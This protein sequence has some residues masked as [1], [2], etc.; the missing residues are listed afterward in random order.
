M[1]IIG[2]T[3]S[4]ACGKSTVSSYLISRGFPVVD[5]DR[6]SRNLTSEGSPV[7]Q[8][9]YREFGPDVFCTDGSLNRRRLGRLVFNDQTARKKLDD[10]MAP[11]LY[12]STRCQI[13]ELAS[14]GE[15]LCF[16]DMP[17]LFEKGYDKLCD[18][19]WTVWLPE[20]IQIT[21]LM[22]R[23]GFSREESLKRIRSVL[24]SDEKAALADKIIDNSGSV[25]QTYAAVADLIAEESRARKMQSD[26]SDNDR[27]SVVRH[28]S[29]SDFSCSMAHTEPAVMKRPDTARRNRQVR[30]TAWRLPAWLKVSLITIAA[31][32]LVGITAQILMRAYLHNQQELHASEQL[33][34]DRQYPL[35]YRDLIIRY[36]S[37]YN[38]SPA[39]VSAI[40]RNE[41]SFQAR[42]ESGAGAR[43]LM[44][45]MPETA[46]WIAGKLQVAGYAFERMYDPE[47]NI[48]FGCW[49]LNY[50]SRL[51][52][53]DPVSVAAAYHAGQGQVKTWL[54]DPLLSED[55]YTM[56]VESLPEGPTKNYTRRVLRDYGIYQEKYFTKDDFPPDPDIAGQ[57]HYVVLSRNR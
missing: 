7:L 47:Y 25:V 57:H 53:G 1:R 32:M 33:E 13:D 12:S 10:L 49:Y 38:L 56:L 24:S 26:Q 41:S 42:A 3:G 18:T 51:F 20:E 4:I 15:G 6:I 54:S 23:D 22:E 5:G 34:I 36:A 39:F 11:Y 52:L 45:L 40:I 21:R 19:V 29:E 44:Q 30:L 14:R 48:M 9:I 50:L 28:E 2:L 17:L 16:L 8:E 55:G 31:I 37:D 27:L 35:A 43:G 46:E